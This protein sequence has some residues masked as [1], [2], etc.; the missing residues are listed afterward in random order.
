MSEEHIRE[1][2]LT[3]ELGRSLRH[4]AIVFVPLAFL[5][6]ARMAMTYG[7]D[8]FTPLELAQVAGTLFA[9]LFSVN[10]SVYFVLKAIDT[11][12]QEKKNDI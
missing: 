10:V 5:L 1:I 7:A 8:L 11:Y 2:D 9:L 6:Q 3:D 12:T 4:T